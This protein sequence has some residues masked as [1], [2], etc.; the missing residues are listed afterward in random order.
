VTYFT[1]QEDALRRFLG[2]GR[3][4]I[5]NNDSERELRALVIGLNNWLYFANETGLKWFTTYRSLIASCLL[6]KL[7]PEEYLEQMLRLAPHWPVTRVLEL[8]PKYW[9]LTVAGLNERQRAILKRPMELESRTVAS[10]RPVPD[11]AE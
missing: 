7:N 3:I 5:H 2:D 1:N 10:V 11:A 6:H 4:P 8:A 9:R